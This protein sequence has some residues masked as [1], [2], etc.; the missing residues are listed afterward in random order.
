MNQWITEIMEQFGY[1]GIYFMMALE[2]IFPPIPSEVVLPFG[3]FMTTETHLSIG[4]VIFY[5]TA[6]SLTGA[7]ILYGIGTLLEREKLYELVD[8]FGKS[9]R[10]TKRDIQKADVWFEKY[11]YWTVFL[12]RMVPLIRSL[13][14]L[15][16]GMARMPL[17]PFLLFTMAGTLL[18]NTF[19]VRLGAVLGASWMDIL[20]FVKLYSTFTYGILVLALLLFAVLIL[21]RKR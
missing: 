21:K 11:G 3:G 10:I 20:H 19:L 12:C 9:V 8:R 15:P 14:S 1:L 18:W 6:G 2:N 5:S 13:I 4:G 17:I 16:A 7:L